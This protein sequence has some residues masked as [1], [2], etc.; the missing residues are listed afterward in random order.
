MKPMSAA[1]RRRI[2]NGI[3]TQALNMWDLY[4]AASNEVQ[5][6]YLLNCFF[7]L[8]ALLDDEKQLIRD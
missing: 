8:T 7:A 3:E 2:L 6:T 1:K 4:L 5:R